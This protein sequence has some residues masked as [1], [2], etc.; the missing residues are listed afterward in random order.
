MT[1]VQSWVGVALGVALLVL[2]VQ[3]GLRQALRSSAGE[4]QGAVVV[5][6]RQRAIVLVEMLVLVLVTLGP[7]LVELLT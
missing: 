2:L 6:R 7:R 3:E 1:W 5:E 4:P